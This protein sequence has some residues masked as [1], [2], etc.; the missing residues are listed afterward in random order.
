MVGSWLADGFTFGMAADLVYTCFHLPVV[1][2]DGFFLSCFLGLAADRSRL[3]HRWEIWWISSFLCYF[4][5]LFLS[6]H[7]GTLLL[8]LK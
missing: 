2:R 3:A 7:P 6:P 1:S 8:I 5:L 4:R